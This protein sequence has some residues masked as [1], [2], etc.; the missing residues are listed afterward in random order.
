MPRSSIRNSDPPAFV[1]K[2]H[3]LL[4]TVW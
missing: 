4:A 2:T 1:G 3:S